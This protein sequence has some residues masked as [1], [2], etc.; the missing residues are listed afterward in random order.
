MGYLEL[1][2]EFRDSDSDVCVSLHPVKLGSGTVLEPEVR[3]QNLVSAAD[4]SWVFFFFFE[5]ILF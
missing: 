3:E 4:L 5:F 2:F 1:T